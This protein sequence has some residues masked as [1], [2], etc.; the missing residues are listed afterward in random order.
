[1]IITSGMTMT[2]AF[3]PAGLSTP[4]TYP[5]VAIFVRDMQ[6]KRTMIA[7]NSRE[8]PVTARFEGLGS[9]NGVKVRFEDRNLVMTGG[10]FSDTFAP[11]AVHIYK[12]VL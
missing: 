2:D 10:S 6:G 1:M 11:L 4:I 12:W 5:S 8:V 9:A 3:T 7:V